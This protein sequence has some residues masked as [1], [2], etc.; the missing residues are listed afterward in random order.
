MFDFLKLC[1]SYEKLSTLE[2]SALLAEKSLK[3]V[4]GLRKMDIH[5]V[6]AVNTLASFLIGSV[7]CDGDVNEVEYLLIYPSLV[8]VFGDSFDYETIKA[9]FKGAEGKKVVKEC[10]AQMEEIYK[11]FDEEMR[12]DVF[13]LCLCVVAIDGKISLKERRYLRRL[14]S[15]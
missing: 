4:S 10:V 3:V 1:N 14:G 15:L 2:R 11:L 13:T 6:D 5:G 8:A 7:V 12:L 9:T